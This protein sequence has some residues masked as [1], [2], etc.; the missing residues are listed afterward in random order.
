MR[1]SNSVG[2]PGADRAG[3]QAWFAGRCD[4][5]R[6]CT[7]AFVLLA[8]LVAWAVP[9]GT[10]ASSPPDFAKQVKPILKHHCGKC[11]S[12]TR[13]KGGFSI[14]TRESLL[15]GGDSGEV[16]VAGESEESYFIDLLQEDAPDLR[17][18]QESPPLSADE[19]AI[20]K[21]W[22]DADLPWEA[23]YA[24]GEQHRSAALA[25]RHVE[26]PAGSASANPIDRLL[27]VYNEQHG[28]TPGGP[29]EDRL[30]CRRVSLDLV[31][32]LPTAEQLA[33]FVSDT[34]PDKRERLVDQLLS[35]RRAYAEHWLS[36]WNDLLRNAYRGT[37]FIDEGRSQITAWLYKSL[38]DNKPYDRMVH[39]LISPVDGSEGFIRGIKWR[40]TVNDSQRREMQAAQNVSQVF[41]GTN[42]KCASCHDSFVNNWKVSDSYGLAAVFSDEAL[43]IHR[44]NRPTGKLATVSFIYPQLGTI[45]P[46]ASREQRMRELADMIVQPANGR[47]ARTIV[48]RLWAQMMGRGLVEPLDDMD[49]E[50]WSPDL[51]D[52]LATDLVDH[53]YDLKRTLQLIC[54]SRAYQLP[55]A[56]KG[57]ESDVAKYDF[58][59]PLVKRMTAEQFIDAICSIRAIGRLPRP[60]CCSATVGGRAV[61]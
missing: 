22:I 7:K 21:A 40:G 17:M 19:I 58:R 38:Y 57:I 18:P 53:H 50:P 42:I 29:V 8:V 43:E 56:D 1:Y 14:N 11:H 6:S 46:A 10:L 59:G 52:F 47:L 36:L 13:R 3:D 2:G 27:G 41:L 54:T 44:C 20:L 4:S 39:E 34:T 32:L 48:N 5:T 31:G 9:D 15:A 49:A 45:T 35:D 33:Q 26:L 60:T 37:G 28:I 51:L 16:V 25:P 61:N 12:G 30:F 23:G 24:F 55:A